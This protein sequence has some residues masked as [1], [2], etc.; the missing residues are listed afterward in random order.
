MACADMVN[1]SGLKVLG[2][3]KKVGFNSGTNV[4]KA[5]CMGYEIRSSVCLKK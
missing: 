4:G 1:R 5:F 2:F 3:D